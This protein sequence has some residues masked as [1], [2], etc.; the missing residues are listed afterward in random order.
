MYVFSDALAEAWVIEILKMGHCGGNF[1]L[2][3]RCDVEGLLFEGWIG[4]VVIYFWGVLKSKA[5]T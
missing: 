2:V 5:K 1:G 3:G 4:E